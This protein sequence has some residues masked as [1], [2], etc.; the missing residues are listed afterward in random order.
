MVVRDRSCSATARP[1]GG[2]SPGRRTDHPDQ[3]PRRPGERW[4]VHRG[5]CAIGR[6]L[7]AKY[8]CPDFHKFR[9]VDQTGI[10]FDRQCDMHV[11]YRGDRFWRRRRRRRT[12]D[13]WHS[14]IWWRGRRWR[15]GLGHY[16]SY[17][18]VHQHRHCDDRS[19]RHGWR[20]RSIRRQWELDNVRVLLH[21]FRRRWWGPWI[22]R[23]E[24]W[25]ISRRRRRGRC[26]GIHHE[27]RN[28]WCRRGRLG[29]LR[30]L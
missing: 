29:H 26:P 9:D 21:R 13:S 19:R 16:I 6:V 4:D 17:F 27:Q 11:T 22:D 12:R 1:C 23:C 8:R 24:C 7:S 5:G 28:Y 2:S 3:S 18:G 30:K 15:G 14:L 10:L 20:V 25:R